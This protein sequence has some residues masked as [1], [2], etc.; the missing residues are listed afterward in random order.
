[1]SKMHVYFYK[2]QAGRSFAA[3]A[4]LSIVSE[5]FDN[6]SDESN[7]ENVEEYH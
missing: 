7:D 6:D 1:M 3:P 5:D 2:M 4:W